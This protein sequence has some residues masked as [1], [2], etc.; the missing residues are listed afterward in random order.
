[1]K[2]D[3]LTRLKDL[4]FFRVWAVYF[5][6]RKGTMAFLGAYSSEE[7][8]R[9]RYDA[10]MAKI[11]LVGVHKDIPRDRITVFQYLLDASK[12]TELYRAFTSQPE[13]EFGAIPITNDTSEFA[14]P[15]AWA[16]PGSASYLG[17]KNKV[18]LDLDVAY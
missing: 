7:K 8:A 2:S 1:M 18:T 10:C 5:L 17:Q 13:F 16:F 12:G 4:L 3:D 11:P 6:S 9:A 14:Q 15:L